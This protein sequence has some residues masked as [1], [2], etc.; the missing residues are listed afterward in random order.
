MQK[1]SICKL[2]KVLQRQNTIL[3]CSHN[4]AQSPIHLFS[5]TKHYGHSSLQKKSVYEEGLKEGF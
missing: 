5:I 2:D 4:Q 3:K 1:Y